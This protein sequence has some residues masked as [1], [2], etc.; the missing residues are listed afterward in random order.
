MRLKCKQPAPVPSTASQPSYD[1][2][3]VG[4]CVPTGQGDVNWADVSGPVTVV[5][6]DIGLDGNK[7][8][9]GCEP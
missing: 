5:G 2:D 3:Y 1:P 7:D 6:K 8:G 4:T 9:Q